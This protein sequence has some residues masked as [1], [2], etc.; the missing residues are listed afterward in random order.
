MRTYAGNLLAIG[1]ATTA[2]LAAGQ[3]GAQQAIT[4]A[5]SGSG[6]VFYT[7]AVGMSR[8]IQNHTDVNV[9]VESV[10]GSHP[11]IFAIIKEQA[12]LAVVNVLAAVD[13]YEGKKPFPSKADLRL[14]AQGNMSLRQV[15]VRR[16]AGIKTPKDLARATWTTKIPANPD[17]GQI[18]DA[19]MK[20][21]DIDPSSVK[22]V[23]MSATS[24]V[25]QGFESRTIDA[26]TM[27]ASA[28]AP[29]ITRLFNDRI[30]DYLQI[31]KEQGQAMKPM[32]PRGMSV[33]TLDAGTYP[34]QDRDA[35]V[36]AVRTVLVADADTPDDVVYKVAKALFDN[37]AELSKFHSTAKHWTVENTVDEP[38][39]PLHA[40]VVRYLKE[41][42]AWSD[43]LAAD[44]AKR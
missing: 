8:V 30:I 23:T 16:D 15:F 34:N 32:L 37:G 31:S 22:Q 27:P 11:S 33:R 12:D 19:L 2:L 3:A 25:V 24:E 20:V 17:I 18:S 26:A 41:K 9:S 44:Q 13:G 39:L 5:T 29:H 6:S 42:G 28:R 21:A 38:P 1:L 4:I 10:G 36:F 40:G 43:A 7:N 35:V 14:V